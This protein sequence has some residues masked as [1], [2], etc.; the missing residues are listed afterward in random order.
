MSAERRPAAYIDAVHHLAWLCCDDHE[1]Q[2]ADPEIDLLAG[3]SADCD[4]PKEA[5]PDEYVQAALDLLRLA[6]HD[7]LEAIPRGQK[8]RRRE[9]HAR[10]R[11]AIAALE[12]P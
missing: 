10:I 12:R 11:A 3:V 9:L 8:R 4:G 5:T 7:A 2:H 1:W 6:E